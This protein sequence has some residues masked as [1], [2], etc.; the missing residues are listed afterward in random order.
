MAQSVYARAAS[1]GFPAIDFGGQT[2]EGRTISSAGGVLSWQDHGRSGAE[3]RGYDLS[4]GQS[5]RVFGTA[6]EPGETGLEW[7]YDAPLWGLGGG[8]REDALPR[9]ETS[10]LDPAGP[11]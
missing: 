2:G 5:S 10:E 3:T 6:A 1:R 9:A 11:R 4:A 8:D 7:V